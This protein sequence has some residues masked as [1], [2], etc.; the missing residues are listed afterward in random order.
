MAWMI[1]SSLSCVTSTDLEQVRGAVGSDD[2]PAVG[3]PREVLDHQSVLDGVEHVVVG[4][5]VAPS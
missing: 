5:A 1:N 3:V 4:H 2:E